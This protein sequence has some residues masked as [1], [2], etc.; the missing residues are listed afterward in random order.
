[1]LHFFALA[2]DEVGLTTTGDGSS[3]GSSSAL[4]ARVAKTLVREIFIIHVGGTRCVPSRTGNIMNIR[5]R[6]TLTVECIRTF[7]I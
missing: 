4:M 2:M 5:A 7:F 1:M 6:I 3:D